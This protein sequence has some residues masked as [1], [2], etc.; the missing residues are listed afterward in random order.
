MT[1]ASYLQLN[2]TRKLYVGMEPKEKD[3]LRMKLYGWFAHG[4]RTVGGSKI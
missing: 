3:G 4:E 2:R 1:Y